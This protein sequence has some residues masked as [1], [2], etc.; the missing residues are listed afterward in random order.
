[1]T[2]ISYYGED[3]DRVVVK[4]NNK[5]FIAIATALMLLATLAN[6]QDVK[7]VRY[8]GN[9]EEVIVRAQ[10]LSQY[11]IEPGVIRSGLSSEV[12]IHIY[13]QKTD[14]WKYVATEPKQPKR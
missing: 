11:D 7:S 10:D 8:E 1:M 4:S 13:D 14:T 2:H 12:L 6:A 3:E 5:K 9:V